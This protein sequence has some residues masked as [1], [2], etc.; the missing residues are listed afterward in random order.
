MQQALNT[1]PL[2]SLHHD[3]LVVRY[4]TANRQGYQENNDTPEDEEGQSMYT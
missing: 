3:W 1:T 4:D 2:G